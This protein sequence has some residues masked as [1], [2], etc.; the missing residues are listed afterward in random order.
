M[1]LGVGRWAIAVGPH[2]DCT[3]ALLGGM[4][5]VGAGFGLALP[6]FLAAATGSLPAESYATGAGVINMLRQIG[7][8]VGVAVV[9]AILGAAS[10]SHGSLGSFDAGWIVIAA[11]ALASAVLSVVTLSGLAAH[12]SG[13]SEAPASLRAPGIVE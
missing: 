10:S 3:G 9:V 6:T 5:L 4:L 12:R 8:A 1:I 7:T 13:T 2:P 11:L